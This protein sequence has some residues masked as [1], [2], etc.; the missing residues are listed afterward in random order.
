MLIA[1]SAGLFNANK[2]LC[3]L[4]TSQILKMFMTIFIASTI[5]KYFSPSSSSTNPS[6]AFSINQYIQLKNLAL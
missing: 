1:P 3:T 5:F 4:V 2:I 6:F